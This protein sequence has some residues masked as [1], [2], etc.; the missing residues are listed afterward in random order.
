MK[1]SSEVGM[2]KWTAHVKS[3]GLGNFLGSDLPT[4]TPGKVSIPC[5]VHG[6]V[7][8]HIGQEDGGFE[9]VCF[10]GVAFFKPAVDLCQ[11]VF[12]LGF[13]IGFGIFGNHAGEEDES[14][15]ADGFGV[16]FGRTEVSDIHLIF[17]EV[18]AHGAFCP[19]IGFRFSDWVGTR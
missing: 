10:V 5:F 14:S 16:A 17:L 18:G 9:D 6:G 1:T 11:N 3:F 15:R 13:G 19:V 12:G 7:V 8:V 4:G 2:E